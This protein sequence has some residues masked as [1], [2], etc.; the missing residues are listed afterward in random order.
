MNRKNRNNVEL[1]TK[2]SKI[3]LSEAIGRAKKIIIAFV[4]ILIITSIQ[5]VNAQDV[6]DEAPNFTVDLVSGGTF[7]LSEQSG[8]VVL[9][10]FFGNTCP[11]CEDSGPSVQGLYETYM[12][13]SDFVAI[14]LDTWDNTSNVE[15]VSNFAASTGITFPLALNA[16]SVKVD[17]SWNY[18]RIVVIDKEGIIRRKANTA[19]D[20]DIVGSSEVIQ[21][22]LDA[23]LGLEEFTSFSGFSLYP[24]PARDILH[25]DIDLDEASDVQMIISDITGKERIN[26][27]YILGSGQQNLSINTEDLAQGLY[28]Y[29][30][31]VKDTVEAGKF[32]IQ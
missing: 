13:N 18:D 16:N 30:I 10:Y 29:T 3:E 4:L 22:Y 17:Y 1:T 11:N 5:H 31:R 6:G 28:L 15:S 32:L 9:I 25:M 20:N 21:T 12:D 26:L 27:S 24:I 7:T 14:G 19:A 8:K 23:P 2:G